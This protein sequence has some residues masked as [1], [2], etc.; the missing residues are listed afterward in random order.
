MS[1]PV[2]GISSSI[3]SSN[4]SVAFRLDPFLLP[5]V[6]VLLRE[7]P[8]RGVGDCK[9]GSE[10]AGEGRRGWIESLRGISKGGGFFKGQFK[11]HPHW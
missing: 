2:V 10:V 7:D 9:T 5:L 8:P 3:G 11:Y 4:N 6:S 1:Q